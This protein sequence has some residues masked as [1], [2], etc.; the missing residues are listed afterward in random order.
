[1]SDSFDQRPAEAAG[2]DATMAGEPFNGPQPFDERRGTADPASQMDAFANRPVNLSAQTTSGSARAS[3][4]AHSGP[5]RPTLSGG[6]EPSSVPVDGGGRL[7][8]SDALVNDGDSFRN[9]WSSVQVGFVDDPRRAVE[10]AEQLVTDVIAD[11]VDGFRQHRQRL[12]GDRDG[13]TDELRAAF[14]RYRDFF[15]RLLNV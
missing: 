15:D 5:D 12:D 1:M 11:L 6:V 9:R 4:E 3:F 7:P 10:E 8:G 14:Q 13:S 2:S